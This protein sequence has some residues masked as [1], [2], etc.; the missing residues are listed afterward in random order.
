MCDKRFVRSDNLAV[1]GFESLEVNVLELECCERVENGTEG[2]PETRFVKRSIG[3][4]VLWLSTLLRI[5]GNS[6]VSRWA[7]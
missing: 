7:A 6:R 5:W 2:D 3:E 1:S 4:E